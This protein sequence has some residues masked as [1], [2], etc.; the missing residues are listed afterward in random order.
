MLIIGLYKYLNIALWCQLNFSEIIIFYFEFPIKG[1]F[2]DSNNIALCQ[3]SKNT[4]YEQNKTK[5]KTKDLLPDFF[6]GG[7][8]KE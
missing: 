7:D 2:S 1:I 4:L 8:T 5:T 3:K 6:F